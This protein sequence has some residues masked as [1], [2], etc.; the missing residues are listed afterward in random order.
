[1]IREHI[2]DHPEIVWI[3]RTGYPSFAQPKIIH[4]QECGRDITFENVYDD[5]SHEY[6]CQECLLYFHRKE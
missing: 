3:Q 4:C 2:P 1:M 5:E 6:L